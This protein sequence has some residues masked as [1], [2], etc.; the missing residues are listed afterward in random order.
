M[1][2]T[3]LIWYVAFW[4]ITLPLWEGELWPHFSKAS[5]IAGAASAVALEQGAMMQVLTYGGGNGGGG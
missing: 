3:L 2:M 1:F 5:R 4:K